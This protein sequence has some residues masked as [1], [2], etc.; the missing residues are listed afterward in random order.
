MK[1]NSMSNERM[2]AEIIFGG[3]HKGEYPGAFPPKIEKIIRELV[4][5]DKPVLHLFSGS[6]MIGD[7]RVDINPDSNATHKVDVFEFLKSD[8][9]QSLWKWVIADPDYS[10]EQMHRLKRTAGISSQGI[11]GDVYKS[12]ALKLFM[13]KWAQNIL[14]LD[15]R[16]PKFSNCFERRYV[17]LVN[18]GGWHD[19]RILQWL[20][21]KSKRLKE[22]FK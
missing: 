7:V 18:Q 2:K 13:I 1:P 21:I 4:S 16:M 3:L 11:G 5:K 19:V 22:V 20:S 12:R 6:S 10:D 17:W 15:R 14:W 9:S 8:E